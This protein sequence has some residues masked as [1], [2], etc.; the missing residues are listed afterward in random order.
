MVLPLKPRTDSAVTLCNAYV[1]EYKLTPLRSRLAAQARILAA[2][3]KALMTVRVYD[4]TGSLKTNRVVGGFIGQVDSQIT[5]ELRADRGRISAAAIGDASE[6]NQ[7]IV[8]VEDFVGGQHVQGVQMP[9][10]LQKNCGHWMSK[11]AVMV[12]ELFQGNLH[13]DE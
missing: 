3:K 4:P 10:K 12:E 1:A 11:K 9:D 7:W 8:N 5:Y 6:H 13:G 2:R